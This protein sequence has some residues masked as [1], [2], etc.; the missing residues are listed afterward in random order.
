MVRAIEVI[1]YQPDFNKEFE[2]LFNTLSERERQVLDLYYGFHNQTVQTP[3][4]IAEQFHLTPTRILQIR[5]RALL[6]MQWRARDKNMERVLLF[7]EFK[8]N[9]I[10]NSCEN[11]IS[12]VLYNRRVHRENQMYKTE[13]SLV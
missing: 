3:K 2:F 4:E 9:G 5:T 11:S 1:F 7:I 10:G 6:R 12:E 13:M 8:F